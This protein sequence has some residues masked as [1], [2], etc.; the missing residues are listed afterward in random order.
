MDHRLNVRTQVIDRHVHGDLG[1]ALQP[2]GYFVSL[3]VDDDQ[4]VDA[5][6]ALA[7]AGGSGQDPFIIQADRDIAVIG[8]DPAFLIDELPDVD[9]ILPILPLGFHHANSVSYRVA[10]SP[11]KERAGFRLVALPL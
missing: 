8:R 2:P 5:H 6:H 7:D 9:N 3:V 11:V 4:I 10:A 1:G